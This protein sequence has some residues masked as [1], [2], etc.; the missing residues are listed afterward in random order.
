MLCDFA[1]PDLCEPTE[2]KQLDSGG[3]YIDDL[4]GDVLDAKLT[5]A[6]R[7]EEID[8]FTE[9][10]VYDVIDRSRL[11]PGAKLVGVRW[12]DTNKGTDAAPRI[13]SRLVC[14]EFNFGGDPSGE[15][16]APTPPLGATRYLLSS[17]ASRG[18]AGPGQYRAML[19][20]F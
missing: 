8:I 13:R 15:M 9:R 16:F 7:K 4:K 2:E 10:R 19:L 12:V 11:P 3:Q 6:A 20:D 1:R 18:R 5:H 17:V 14:Q